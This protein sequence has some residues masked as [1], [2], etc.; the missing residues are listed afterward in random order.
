MESV[1]K[2]TTKRTQR[3]YSLSFKLA[4]V[5]EVEK[6][7]LTS[8][9]AQDKYGIQG[10]STVLNWLRKHGRLDWSAGSPSHQ[11]KKECAMPSSPSLTPEQRIKELEQ[12]LA[13]S[14]Q[15]A[16][17]FEAVVKVLERDHGVS[18]TKKRHGK[19]SK[20]KS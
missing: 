3:D 14:E 11:L 2:S 20:K 5:D 17:F 9:Q 13:L 10:R 8:S 7:H 6:G 12:K 15:K 19:S 18:L 16:E 1:M 4:V